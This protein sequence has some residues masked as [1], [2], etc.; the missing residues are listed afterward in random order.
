MNTERTPSAGML[1]L[2]HFI[3]ALHAFAVFSA[4]LGSATIVF[5]FVASLPSLAAIVLNYWNR[6][7]VRG[8][9]LDSHFSWQIRS[10]WWTL[11]WIVIAAV[12]V[13][14][15]IGI[16]FAIAAFGIVSVWVV[17]RVVRGWWRLADG[18]PMPM[19]PAA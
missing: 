2:T 12:A 14:T 5:S 6:S 16:P 4:V 18:Q 1:R 15:L 17:Y 19:P 11:A 8:T 10:F 3:Y 7:A 9:W 13:F